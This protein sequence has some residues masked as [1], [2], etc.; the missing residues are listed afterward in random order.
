MKDFLPI[1]KLACLTAAAALIVSCGGG[2]D[3]RNVLPADSFVTMSV[4][5]ASLLKKSGTCDAASNPLLDR[6]KAELDK[7]EELS[8]EEKEYL[9][10]LLENPAESGLDLK[11][12][13]FLFMSAD[14]ADINNPEVGGGLL[15]PVGD[16][17]KLDALIARINE[18]SG[19]ETVTEAGVSV[20]KIGEESEASGVC[21]YNDI[22]CLLY[23]KTDPC[24]VVEEKVRKLFAQKR[25]E[26]LMGDK[27]VAARL[28]ARNDVNMVVSYANLSAMMNNPMLGAMPM[29]DV[30]KGA[31]V[32][33]SANFEKGRIVSDAAVSY[34]DKASVEKAAAFYAYVKPQTGDL[35]RYV[36]AGS[37]AALSYGLDGEKLYAMLAAMPGYGMMLGNPMVKQVLDAFDGDCVISFSGM[38]PDGRFPIASL[39][40][41]VNDPAVLQT[42]VTN[43]GGHA[44]SAD[45]RGRVRVQFGRCFGAV[46]REEQ[47]ALLHDRHGREVGPRRCED[48][49]ADV[50]RRHRE[51]AVLHL[52]GRFQG[53]ERPGFP[54]D[55]RGRDA[56][57][58]SRAGGARHVRRYGC[59]Q[60]D[61]GRK[62]RRQHG[63]Q[64]AERFQDHLRHDR[65]TDPSVYAGSGRNLTAVATPSSGRPDSNGRF[66]E[67]AGL[68]RR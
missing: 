63:R 43:L 15:F 23:F 13:L 61:G 21:A 67:T 25:A 2:A 44:R 5:A 55:R 39:L 56:A 11:K 42:V 40:A 50:A 35:L 20:V 54:T 14:G 27:A 12:E 3:Y 29:M 49:I 10:S 38:T 26:S 46:R 6:L 16:K 8:A 53:A 57:G 65:R 37:L 18:K 60:H 52:L 48:R 4:D 1:V 62:A 24:G 68:W 34:K 31:L 58:G 51:R 22:A 66:F 9:F 33:G 45:R 30:L 59:V 7:A 64:G 17:S 41:Q 32:M 47:G 19:T 36:P 28:A